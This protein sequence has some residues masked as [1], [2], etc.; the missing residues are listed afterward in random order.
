MTTV[1][2]LVN[3]NDGFVYGVYTDKEKAYEHGSRWPCHTW[4]VV[5][6]IVQ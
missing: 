4:N 2:V 5:E 3:I 1:F 6:R